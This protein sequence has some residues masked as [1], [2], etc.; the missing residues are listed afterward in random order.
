M[1]GEQQGIYRRVIIEPVGEGGKKKLN[2]VPNKCNRI[3][4]KARWVI[5]AN[6]YL[7]YCQGFVCFTK[8]KSNVPK[9]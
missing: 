1:S 7:G 9:C 3:V 6:V 8:Y 5:Q 2:F 4:Y